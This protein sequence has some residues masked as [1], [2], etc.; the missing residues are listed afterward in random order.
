MEL[1]LHTQPS[2]AVLLRMDCG[3]PCSG[4]VDLTPV[5][6]AMD[7][8][9][10]NTVSVPV[11]CFARRGVDLGRVNTPFLMATRGA[12][13]VDIAEIAIREVPVDNTLFDCDG[14][15]ANP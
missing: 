6:K 10:W 11:A 12:L 5:L 9:E 4:A 3:W 13:T 2:D 7:A 15:V 8:G 1:R 14:L